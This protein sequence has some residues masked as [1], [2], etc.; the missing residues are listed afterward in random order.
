MIYSKEKIGKELINQL[1]EG[2]DVK[3]IAKWAHDLFFYNREQ[4]PQDINDVL[5]YLLLMDAG[6]EFENTESQLRQLAIS[7][8][9]DEKEP[10]KS[11]SQKSNSEIS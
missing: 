2:Y 3:R 8:L 1:N 9:K 6:P 5:Q 4:F 11:L 10:L 7:L